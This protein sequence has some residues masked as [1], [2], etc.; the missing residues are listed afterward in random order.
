LAILVANKLGGGRIASRS[1]TAQGLA[2]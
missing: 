2:S 1:G